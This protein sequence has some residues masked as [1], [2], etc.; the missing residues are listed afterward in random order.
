MIVIKASRHPH[1]VLLLIGCLLWGIAG[2]V[3]FE[4]VAVTS[5]RSL[6]TPWG[7]VFYILLAVGAAVPLFGIFRAGITGA[8]IERAGLLILAGMCLA[9]AVAIAFTVPVR[10]LG[11]VLLMAALGVAN[12]IRALQIPGEIDR[13][14]AAA[15]ATGATDQLEG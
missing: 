6:P 3:A 5:V 1:E 14:T 12:I 8:L 13:L 4:Q 2:T 11:F 10:G 9:F 7:L 15:A